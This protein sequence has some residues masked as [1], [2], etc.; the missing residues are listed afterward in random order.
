MVVESTTGRALTSLG[1]CKTVLLG[2]SVMSWLSCA[3]YLE[4][5]VFVLQISFV[6]NAPLDPVLFTLHI[7]RYPST[8][9]L[10][11]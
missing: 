6:P 3:K 2:A 5:Y 4:W 1:M 7:S 9:G 11:S 10:C 8:L